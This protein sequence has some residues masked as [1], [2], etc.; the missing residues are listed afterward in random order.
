MQVRDIP[1]G[2]KGGVMINFEK[3]EVRPEVVAFY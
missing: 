3:I 1:C 2:T